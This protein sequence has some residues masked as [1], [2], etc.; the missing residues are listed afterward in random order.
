MANRPICGEDTPDPWVIQWPPSSG[1]FYM[2]RLASI[3]LRLQHDVVRGC[4]DIAPEY[5]EADKSPLK[6]W[7]SLEQQRA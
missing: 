5:L 4:A 2:V 7:Q 3:Q 6:E 1:L